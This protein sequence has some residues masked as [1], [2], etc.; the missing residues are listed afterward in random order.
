MMKDGRLNA[1]T[2]DVE[3]YFQVSAFENVFTQN[4]WDKTPLRV[5]HNTNRLLDLFD[6]HNVKAT[7]FTLAWVAQKCPSLIKRIVSEGHE[8]A[9]H[10]VAHRRVSTMT[11]EEFKEDAGSSKQILEDIGGVAVNGYRAP[12]FSIN[13]ANEWAFDIV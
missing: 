13:G 10:G 7:F 9:S 1:M 4:D 11:P 12:S 8:L 3:D 6:E 5:D 2:V